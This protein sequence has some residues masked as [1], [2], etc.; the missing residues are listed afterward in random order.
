MAGRHWPY[1][2]IGEALLQSGRKEKIKLI[3]FAE[4]STGKVHH[5]KP[6]EMNPRE[7]AGM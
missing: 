1:S 6:F 2:G 7:A 5:G 3:P 4:D